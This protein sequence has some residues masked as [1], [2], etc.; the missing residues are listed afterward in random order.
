MA[1]ARERGQRI[2]RNTERALSRLSSASDPEAVHRFRTTVLRLEILLEQLSPGGD[3]KRKKLLKRLQRIRKGAGKVRDI[4]VQ[5]AALGTLR[6]APEPRRKR[7]LAEGL[8]ELRAQHESKLR[9]LL[10][11]SDIRELRKRLARAAKEANFEAPLDPLTRARQMLESAPV[12]PNPPGE[13]ALHRYRRVVKRARYAAEFAP[14]STAR[15]L[16]IAQ[17]QRLEDAIG[18]WHDWFTLT[19]TAVN[20][21]GDV[22]QSALVAALH[23]V[24]GAKF[25]Q[26]VAV[27]SP[28][29]AA[30]PA[31][32]EQKSRTRSGVPAERPGAAA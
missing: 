2:F 15:K 20:R 24:T 19:R 5:L 22:T 31:A 17:L 7:Q 28:P 23:A 16:L 3:R 1:I 13:T 30:A 21:W 4:D 6:I 8:L 27:V 26:A 18:H 25:R 32:V 10:K 14:P 12:A 11:K 29:R 9:K